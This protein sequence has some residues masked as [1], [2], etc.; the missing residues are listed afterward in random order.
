MKGNQVLTIIDNSYSSQ[1]GS[2]NRVSGI[3]GYGCLEREVLAR[4]GQARLMEWK[5][6]E[7]NSSL[8]AEETDC[9]CPFDTQPNHSTAPSP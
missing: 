8:F 6:A 5:E 3:N 4:T 1:L 7:P 2:I 9:V